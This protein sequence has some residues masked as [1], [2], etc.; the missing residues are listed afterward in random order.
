MDARKRRDG[1]FIE[2]LGYFDPMKSPVQ[3]RVD[4]ARVDYWLGQGASPS[5]TVSQIVKQA[6][7]AA[8]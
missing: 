2:Q 3:I 7:K 4:L 5:A 6:R 1:R 8:P